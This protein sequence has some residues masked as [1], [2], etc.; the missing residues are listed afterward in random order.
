MNIVEP[1]DAVL[2]LALI[3]Y[4]KKN[5]AAQLEDVEAQAKSILADTLTA[6]HDRE[7]YAIDG[8][9]L[10]QSTLVT[11]PLKD[12]P[13]VVDE[14]AFAL[15][16]TKNG[17]PEP[18]WQRS[19]VKTETSAD[20][21]AGIIQKTGEVPDGVQVQVT[22]KAPYVRTTIKDKE[23]FAQR[24]NAAAMLAADVA[25]IASLTQGEEK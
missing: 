17:Y 24:V 22:Q 14:E 11:P 2:A 10:A 13:V 4:M 8:Q 20:R 7:G 5:L 16:L 6:E 25:A 1:R 12:T 19:L 9:V 23:A 3:Q 21:I 15:W 18:R